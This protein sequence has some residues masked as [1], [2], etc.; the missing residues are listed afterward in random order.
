MRAIVFV[1]GKPRAGKDTAI[2]F[3]RQSFRRLGYMS[4]EFSSIDPVREMLLTAGIDV[5][6][7]TP[8]DRKLLSRVGDEV[9]DHCSYRSAHCIA[10]ARELFI[11]ASAKGQWGVMFLHTREPKLIRKIAEMAEADLNAI[12]INVL[13][14]SPWE[15]AEA[16]NESD[17]GVNDGITYDYIIENDGMLSHLQDRC[18]SLAQTLVNRLKRMSTNS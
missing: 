17:A 7:K 11:N 13:V 10:A 2:G 6:Q 5:S 12:S 15:I 4:G 14:R 3:L 18:G 1:N 9:E 16:S 8:A